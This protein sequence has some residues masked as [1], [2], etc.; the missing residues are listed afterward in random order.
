MPVIAVAGGTG[1]VGKTIVERLVSEPKHQVIVLSRQVRQ[2]RFERAKYLQI[3]KKNVQGSIQGL[4]SSRFQRVQIDYNDIP[5]MARVLE[6]VHVDTIVSAIGLV[7]D[8]TSQAQLNLIEA[9]EKSRTTKRF[10]PSEFSFIQTEELLHIDPSIKYWLDA[11]NRLKS[12][13]LQ[14]T[15]VVPGFFMDYWGMPNIQ[16][17]LQP[18]SFGINIAKH[19]A[20]IPGNGDDVIC[21]TYSYDMAN[22]L[23]KLLDLDEWPEFSV[24]VGDEVTYNQ[25]LK[26]AEEFTGTKFEVTY[27]S[28]DQVN[29]GNVTIPPNP[30]GTKYSEEEMREVT[31]LVSRLTVNGVF[32]LPKENRLNELFP[33]IHPITMKEL[34]ERSWKK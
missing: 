9:A 4:S 10:I 22:Y 2:D 5:S 15:R 14:F 27:D 18:Y 17:N 24:I 25:I 23:V 33:D 7:S 34:L 1:G 21:T 32:E 31:A 19:S 26:M 20:A 16:S 12:S 13:S 30:P 6:D 3:A 8:E 29:A 11:A 28:V